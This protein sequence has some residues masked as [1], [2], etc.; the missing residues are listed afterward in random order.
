M[1]PILFSRAIRRTRA[2]FANGKAATRSRLRRVT[3]RIPRE[4]D[5][6]SFTRH[7]GI[8]DVFPT[9]LVVPSRSMRRYSGGFRKRISCPGASPRFPCDFAKYSFHT[10]TNRTVGAG[11]ESLGVGAGGYIQ[12]S[13]R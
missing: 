12:R 10:F 6:P 13:E 11:D 9:H 8:F 7:G 2:K 1:E 3:N 4:Q 5:S